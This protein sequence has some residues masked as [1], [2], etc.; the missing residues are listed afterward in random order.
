MLSD[1]PELS[2]YFNAVEM[3]LTVD[4]R[5]EYD[6]VISIMAEYGLKFDWGS[7]TVPYNFNIN[8]LP[9]P[10]DKQVLNDLHYTKTIP[11]MDSNIGYFIGFK[12]KLEWE[13]A[14][15]LEYYELQIT[16]DEELTN[17]HTVIRLT[18]NT[19]EV[20]MV[21]GTYYWRTRIKALNK[22]I[23]DWCQLLSFTIPPASEIIT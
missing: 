23:S 13:K 10:H 5:V 21:P 6:R 11:I 4:D 7:W 20:T 3:T 16:Y 17:I 18:A 15:N 1:H 2:E 12:F 9:F 14:L 22:T 8:A 19:F